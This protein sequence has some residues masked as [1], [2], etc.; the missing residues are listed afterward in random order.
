MFLTTNLIFKVMFKLERSP[1][2]FELIKLY[3]MQGFTNKV[4]GGRLCWG[5]GFFSRHSRRWES[6]QHYRSLWKVC[7]LCSKT[8]NR[9]IPSSFK[10]SMFYVSSFIVNYILKWHC[11]IEWSPSWPCHACDPWSYTVFEPKEV[12]ELWSW[13]SRMCWLSYANVVGLLNDFSE[14]RHWLYCV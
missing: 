10:N 2:H 5:S 4:E 1:L 3:W 11:T 12:Q 14:A 13:F 8:L 7:I 6:A 9:H